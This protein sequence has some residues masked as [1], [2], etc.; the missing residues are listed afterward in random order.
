MNGYVTRQQGCCM[1]TLNVCQHV[2]CRTV[3]NSVQQCNTLVSL[4]G[5]QLRVVVN[6]PQHKCWSSNDCLYPLQ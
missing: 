1:H 2:L 4:M 5:H 3:C 6:I